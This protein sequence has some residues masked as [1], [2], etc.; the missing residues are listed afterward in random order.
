MRRR[1]V[2][3]AALVLAGLAGGA[4]ALVLVLS[5]PSGR[6]RIVSG[7]HRIVREAL[8]VSGRLKPVKAKIFRLHPSRRF[9]RISIAERRKHEREPLNESPRTPTRSAGPGASFVKSSGVAST[10]A[11]AVSDSPGPGDL[12]LFAGTRFTGGHHSF[13]TEP[14]IAANDGRILETWNWGAGLSGDDGETFSFVDPTTAFPESHDGFCC[15]QLAYYVPKSD[16]WIWLIQYGDDEDGN[17]LRLAVAHGSAAFDAARLNATTF[18]L[19]DL[20]PANFGWPKS[21]WFDFNGISSTDQNLFVATNVVSAGAYEGVIIR[22]PLSELASGILNFPDVRYWRTAPLSAPRLVQGAGD[23]MYFAAHA[24]TSRLRVWSWADGSD[25]INR[26]DVAHS[27][28][29][30]V[31]IYHCPR[32]GGPET[33]D[34]CEGFRGGSYKNDD[35]VL[36]GWVAKSRIGFAWNA[37]QDPAHGFRYPFVMAVEIDAQSMKRTAQPIIWSPKYAYQYP[38]IAP[39]ARG[40]LGGIV[41]RGGGKAYESCTALI[42]DSDSSASPSGWD[43]YTLD[44]SSA[45]PAEPRF[46]DYLGV[47]PAGADS[48]TW[49]AGCMGLHGGSARSNLAVDYLAFGRARDAKP[50]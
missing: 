13:T 39:N 34:W 30:H 2:F 6:E 4:I 27:A 18:K 47:A 8:Q 28:Y 29:K 44:A 14:S 42:R 41:L 31:Q 36:A 23:T 21:A 43:A 16:L 20:A 19:F 46:G 17:I 45:D 9:P 48:N 7:R 26:V 33:S 3:V 35:N 25:S 24:N 22:I 5:G 10:V 38:A 11:K 49:V 15:D 37:S 12:A 32:I 50:K 1:R 40:D